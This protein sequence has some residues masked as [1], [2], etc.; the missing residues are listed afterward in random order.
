MIRLPP[1]TMP[2][3]AAALTLFLA[4]EWFLPRPGIVSPYNLA[5]IPVAQPD[6]AADATIGQWGDT[7]LSRPLFHPDRRPVVAVGADTST[8]LPRLSAIIII[9]NKSAAVFV[10]DGQKPQIVGTGGTIDG[11]R[12]ERIAPNGVELLG[13][14]GDQTVRPQFTTTTPANGANN[15]PDNSNISEENNN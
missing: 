10:A 11:Y 9:G 1:L 5:A 3:L 8:S 4:V 15:A 13:P 2:V 14:T 6:S 12:L 7:A